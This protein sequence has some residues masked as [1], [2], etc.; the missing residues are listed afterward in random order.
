MS[1]LRDRPTARSESYSIENEARL[2]QVSNEHTDAT[3]SHEGNEDG[4]SDGRAGVGA[5]SSSRLQSENHA[6]QP[7]PQA[8]HRRRRRQVTTTL[9]LK[10][11]PIK[12]EIAGYPGLRRVSVP[13]PLRLSAIQRTLALSFPD[14]AHVF[15]DNGRVLQLLVSHQA[16]AR[17]RR[18]ARAEKLKARLA[19]TPH[20]E[21]VPRYNNPSAALTSSSS[22]RRPASHRSTNNVT[23]NSCSRVVCVAVA[24]DAGLAAAYRRAQAAHRVL[25]FKVPTLPQHH[26]CTF[27]CMYVRRG[28]LTLTYCKS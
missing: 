6:Q 11:A 19:T 17:S 1:E 28:T 9:A 10:T 27:V 3:A 25:R 2:L 15:L 14:L 21:N 4:H 8:E 22:V 26:A 24:N 16:H 7:E 20:R 5:D 18:I 23:R 12:F 13:L